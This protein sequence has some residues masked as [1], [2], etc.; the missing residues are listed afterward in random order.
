MGSFCFTARIWSTRVKNRFKTK[1][2]HIG[3]VVEPSEGITVLDDSEKRY[4]LE[5]KGFDHFL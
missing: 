1:V 2:T 3:E 4:V 5:K